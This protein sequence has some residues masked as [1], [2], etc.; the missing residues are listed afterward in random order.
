MNLDCDD[1]SDRMVYVDIIVDYTGIIYN[2][3]NTT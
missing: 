3:E 2:I 1:K